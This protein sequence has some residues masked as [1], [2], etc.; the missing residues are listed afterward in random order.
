MT[1]DA[2]KNAKLNLADSGVDCLTA[3]GATTQELVELERM[4]NC[5]I[6]N[7]YREM[8][9]D[10]GIL[11]FEGQFISG[12]GRDG[13]R[14]SN[15]GNVWFAT[16]DARGND[17]IGSKMIWFMPSGYGPNFVL[18]CG[19]LDQRGEAPVYEIN[20]LGFRHG[21]KKVADSFGEFLLNEVAM[22]LANR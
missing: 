15:Y 18:D 7:S 20:E 22:T 16:T 19:Q 9:L 11:G 14:G 4:L 5:P 3:N 17:E 12:I 13:L 8:L 6:P 1:V 10:T 2:Y 21:M